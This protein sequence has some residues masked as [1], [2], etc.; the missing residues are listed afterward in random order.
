MQDTFSDIRQLVIKQN[1]K[2]I[3]RLIFIWEE[4]FAAG[5]RK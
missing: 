2:D 3:T 4:R 1:K 5:I